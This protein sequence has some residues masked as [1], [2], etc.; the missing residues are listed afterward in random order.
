MQPA[1]VT[2]RR[3]ALAACLTI[4][5]SNAH[6]RWGCATSPQGMTRLCCRAPLRHGFICFAAASDELPREAICRRLMERST[7][8]RHLDDA[9]A[10][11]NATSG[12][13]PAGRTA[14]AQSS[15]ERWPRLAHRKRSDAD[16]EPRDTSIRRNIGLAPVS[17]APPWSPPLSKAG[18]LVWQR[19]LASAIYRRRQTNWAACGGR[20]VSPALFE[21]RQGRCADHFVPSAGFPGSHAHVWRGAFCFRAAN[22][23][24]D[25]PIQPIGEPLCPF[26]ARRRSAHQGEARWVLNRQARSRTVRAVP[27]TT[28]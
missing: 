18:A 4:A 22:S 1:G 25:A 19:R 23:A 7:S 16:H 13:T 17:S 26:L 28:G 12:I 21:I 2:A 24:R 3:Q 20:P 11:C 5:S 10:G 9:V 8:S 6:R 27:S 15:D 14:S